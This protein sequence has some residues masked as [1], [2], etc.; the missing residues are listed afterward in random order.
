MIKQIIYRFFEQFNIIVEAAYSCV[1][2][3]A[4]QSAHSACRMV[5]VNAHQA[6]D[7]IGGRFANRAVAPLYCEHGE[8]SFRTNA[9]HALNI[10]MP[11]EFIPDGVYRLLSLTV[12]FGF[13]AL[14]RCKAVSASGPHPIYRLWAII[15]SFGW[16]VLFALITNLTHQ[17]FVWPSRSSQSISTLAPFFSAACILPFAVTRLAIAAITAIGMA[18]T[19]ELRDRLS[20]PTAFAEF[21]G[22][23]LNSHGANLRKRFAKWQGS[24]RCYQHLSE[25]ICILA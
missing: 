10:S 12:S 17:H 11:C 15:K 9:I 22:Y 19:I 14:L 24:L 1:A 13:V 23:T 7:K 8:V 4:Q 16:L 18:A 25:P 2:V 3:V 5:V 6:F 21:F 20:L